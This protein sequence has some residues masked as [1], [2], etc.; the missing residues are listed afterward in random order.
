ML[1]KASKIDFNSSPFLG[2]LTR[3]CLYDLKVTYPHS[4]SG[5]R[6]HIGLHSASKLLN[7]LNSD[8]K[9]YSTAFSLQT[10]KSFNSIL[11][12]IKGKL[13]NLFLSRLSSAEHLEDLILCLNCPCSIYCNCFSYS[14]VFPSYYL[15][16]HITRFKIYNRCPLFVYLFVYFCYCKVQYYIPIVFLH[17][18]YFISIFL[19][20]LLF[21]IFFL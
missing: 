18:V 5:K 9:E 21:C 1:P 10:P 17:I 16:I 19:L 20:A 3:A 13:R 8:L 12:S 15:D 2:R 7:D 6:A 11:S 4:N 14:N